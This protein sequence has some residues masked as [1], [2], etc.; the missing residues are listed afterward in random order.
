M[1][2]SSSSSQ[3]DGLTVIIF[4]FCSPTGPQLAIRSGV[5]V[6][7]SGR[8]GGPFVGELSKDGPVKLVTLCWISSCRLLAPLP[9]LSSP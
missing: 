3:K 8:S 2:C 9:F 7:W 4:R 5:L 6:G 1:V